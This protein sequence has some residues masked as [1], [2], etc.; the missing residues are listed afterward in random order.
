MTRFDGK[1]AVVA[2][3]AGDLGKLLCRALLG[4]KA[5]VVGIDIDQQGGQ[6]L[7]DELR[8]AGEP[9]TFHRVDIA[10]PEAV[11]SFAE[12]C[13]RVD[14]LINA[15][16]IISY[17]PLVET[18][19]EEWDRV[20]DINLRGA[21]LTTRALAPLLAEG[22]AVV[23]VSSSA[24]L[25]A[26]AGWSA[27]SVSKAGLVALSKVAAAELAPRARVNAVCPGALDTQLPH[28]LLDGHPDKDAIMTGMAQASML[29]RLGEAR[30]VVPLCLFLAS[31]EA[32]LLTGATVAA[33]GGTTAW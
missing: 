33:D 14:V 22:A 29:R 19:L 18:S 20:L 21:F 6:R 10:D 12:R 13:D 15:A 8:Q 16:G 1:V 31:D 25:R 11:A 7:Q 23:N 3:A 17:A 32:S 28:R 5:T 24:A 26:G 4:E 2:G 9:F 30:E 27:Y